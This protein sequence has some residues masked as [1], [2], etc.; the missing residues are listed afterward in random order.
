M[1]L[2]N[3]NPDQNLARSF[4]KG[5]Y[6]VNPSGAKGPILELNAMRNAAMTHYTF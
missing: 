4:K 2:R 3:E 5:G 6:N 1:T